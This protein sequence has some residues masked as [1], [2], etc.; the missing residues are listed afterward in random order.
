MAQIDELMISKIADFTKNN[1]TVENYKLDP[2]F[3]YQSLPFCVIDSIYSIG[4]RYETVKKTVKN[5]C[6]YNNLLIFRENVDSIPEKSSQFSVNDFMNMFGQADYNELATSIFRN[7]QRTSSVS[8]VLKA[9]AVV[10]FLKELSNEGINY[11]QDLENI[12]TNFESKIKEIIGQ[13]S[14][15]SLQYF[16]MLAGNDRLIKPDRMVIRYIENVVKESISQKDCQNILEKTSL[17]F[18]DSGVNISPRELDNAIWN[19]QRNIK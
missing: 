3:Y 6:E 4:V 10:H 9:E 16:Y 11:F 12:S 5:F 15:I 18:Q 19:Y 1:I 13:K 2:E 14:G 8:G 7:K 17:K